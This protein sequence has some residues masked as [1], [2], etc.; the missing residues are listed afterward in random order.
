MEDNAMTSPVDKMKIGNA[1]R[2]ARENRGLSQEQLA[3]LINKSSKAIAKY[4]NGKSAP[5]L[6][7]LVAISNA[8]EY[9][10]DALSFGDLNAGD[11]RRR[12]KLSKLLDDTTS[13]E[14]AQVLE[15]MTSE[16][17]KVKQAKIRMMPHE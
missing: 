9:S 2:K 4:E 8:L 15:Y 10:L 3:E 16:V 1:I 11:L 7:M 14:Q 17:K 13:E 12:K 6:K 5:K